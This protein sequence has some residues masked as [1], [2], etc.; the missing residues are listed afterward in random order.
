MKNRNR[1]Q[2]MMD[3]VPMMLIIFSTEIELYIKL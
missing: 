2:R 3:F 1:I